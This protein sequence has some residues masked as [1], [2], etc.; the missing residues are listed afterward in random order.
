[1]NN[2][3]MERTSAAEETDTPAGQ[4]MATDKDE[5]ELPPPPDGYRYRRS[6]SLMGV[7]TAE[8]FL[9]VEDADDE[10]AIEDEVNNDGKVRLSCDLSRRHHRALRIS[11][12]FCDRTIAD[13]VETLIERHLMKHCRRTLQGAYYYDQPVMVRL[14]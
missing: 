9:K 7:P 3:H 2:I 4:M 12:A 13:M 1:M 6:P 8:D 5:A 10:D 14:K 11:A